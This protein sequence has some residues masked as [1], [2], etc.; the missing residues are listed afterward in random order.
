MSSDIDNS[1]TNDRNVKDSSSINENGGNIKQTAKATSLKVVEPAE[2]RDVRR[3]IACIDP[4][5][6]EHLNISSGDVIELSSL[7]S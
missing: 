1:N 7:G 2:Q 4:E 6:A 3:K 5:V